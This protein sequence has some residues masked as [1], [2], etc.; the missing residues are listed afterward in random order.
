M[1]AC[2]CGVVLQLWSEKSPFRFIL[3]AD[4]SRPPQRSSLD[5]QGLE[6]LSFGGAVGFVERGKEVA[7]IAARDAFEIFNG[8]SFPVSAAQWRNFRAQA[9]DSVVPVGLV[10]IVQKFKDS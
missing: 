2:V 8:R 10:P 4:V 9:L 1:C 7:Y 3:H 5:I 6:K